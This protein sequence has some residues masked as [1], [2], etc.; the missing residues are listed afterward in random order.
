MTV[1]LKQ[2]KKKIYICAPFSRGILPDLA[3]DELHGK[4]LRVVYIT[5]KGKH[6]R[7][8]EQKQKHIVGWMD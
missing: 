5:D 7:E 2:T 8:H 1:D 6:L 4:H 3:S